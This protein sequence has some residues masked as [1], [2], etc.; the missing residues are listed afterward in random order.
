MSP[1]SGGSDQ[2]RRVAAAAMG[3]FSDE[4]EVLEEL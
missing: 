2:E 4:D 1:L 3:I